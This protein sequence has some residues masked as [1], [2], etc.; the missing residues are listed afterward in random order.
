MVSFSVRLE[1]ELHEAATE[2]AG[3]RDLSLVAY[4]RQLIHNDLARQGRQVV[5]I[6]F[7]NETIDPLEVEIEYV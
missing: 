3:E 2:R 6:Y 1:D 7:E 4:I 5:R